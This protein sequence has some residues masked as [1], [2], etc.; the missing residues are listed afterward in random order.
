MK[1][2]DPSGDTSDENVLYEMLNIY[3]GC[4]EKFTLMQEDYIELHFKSVDPI[5][6]PIGSHTTWNDKE[7]Y[8]I[9]AQQPSYDESTGGYNYE[10]K[11]EAYYRAWQMKIYKYSPDVNK[12]NGKEVDKEN[13]T[14]EAEFS[15]T[16]NLENQVNTFVRCLNKE[17]FRYNKKEFKKDVPDENYYKEVKTMTYSSVNFIEAL[18]QIADEWDAEWWVEGNVIKFGKCQDA[19]EAIEFKLGENVVSMSGSRS[20]TDYATRVYAFG[21]DKNLPKN[22]GKGDAVFTMDS[23]PQFKD[24][25]SYFKTDKPLYSDFFNK[26]DRL[27]NSDPTFNLNKCNITISPSETSGIYL[28]TDIAESSSIMLGSGEYKDLKFYLDK[29]VESTKF[30][31]CL[32]YSITGLIGVVYKSYEVTVFVIL[33]GDKDGSTQTFNVG[34]EV[35]VENAITSI[36]YP[37]KR[38]SVNNNDNKGSLYLD[39]DDGITFPAFTLSKEQNISIK[40]LV[41]VEYQNSTISKGYIKVGI[42]YPSCLFA[43]TLSYFRN[44]KEVLTRVVVRYQTQ[45]EG[46][47][48][49][50]VE[51]VLITSAELFPNYGTNYIRF[52]GIRKYEGRKVTIDNIIESKLPSWYFDSEKDIQN[53]KSIKAIAERRL[54]LPAPYYVEASSVPFNSLV[55]KVLVFDDIYPRI[56]S[57]I[58]KIEPKPQYVY[59]GDEKTDIKY[60]EYYIHTDDFTFDED[61]KLDT[62]DKLEIKFQTGALSGLTFEAIFH[63]KAI[64]NQEEPPQQYFQIVRQQFDGGIYLPSDAMHPKLGDNFILIGWDASRIEDLKLIE[65]AEGK[66]AERTRF[67]I[68]KMNIDPTTYECTMFSDYTYGLAKETLVTDDNGVVLTDERGI[69]IRTDDSASGLDESNKNI[70]KIGQR[71]KLWNAAFFEN[72]YRDSRIIGYER[73]MDIPYDSPVYMV[74]EKAIYSKFSSLE[75]SIKQIKN[76]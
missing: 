56:E 47:P 35:Q 39:D 36:S 43:N 37:T 32:D 50:T 46:N 73:K 61:Y 20:E 29:N 68:D 5:Y 23:N 58:T 65:K 66:L 42:G 48:T 15:L 14:R 54:S 13:G 9:E 8:I 7:Y 10:L 25:Y 71:V 57:L 21:S 28:S 59:E 76:K 63:P 70:F 49:D 40:I 53:S 6:F 16:A 12:E 41:G 72:G 19:G 38:I 26:S 4:I 62:A 69:A 1:I 22:Y 11:F 55:E 60:T 74:G 17:G 44:S 27:D 24:N 45:E 51:A 52:K 33:C 67:E 2:Y 3:E 34:R 64:F 18:N 75:K 30:G 31:I